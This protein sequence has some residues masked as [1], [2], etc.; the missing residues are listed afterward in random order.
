MNEILEMTENEID[1]HYIIQL[2]KSG[3]LTNKA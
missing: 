1:R 2:L 3:A